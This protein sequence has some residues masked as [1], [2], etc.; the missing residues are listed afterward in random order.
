MDTLVVQRLSEVAKSVCAAH[1]FQY[2][3]SAGHGAF[4]AT[5]EAIN[6]SGSRIA[7]KIYQAGTHSERTTR[8]IDALVRLDHPNLPLFLTLD[9]ITHS[10][11]RYEFSTEEFLDGGTLTQRLARGLLD[12]SAILTLGCQLIQAVGHVASLQLVHRDIKPD[13]IMFRTDGISSVLVDFGLVRDLSL[14][15]L[16]QTWL[17]MGPGT[18]FFAAPEQLNNAKQLIDW[19]TDQFALGVVLSLCG[20]GQHPH[21][22]QGDD[23]ATIVKRVALR[24]QSSEAFRAWAQANSLPALV[25]MTAG[26]P[27]QRFRTPEALLEAWMA[28]Q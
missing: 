12:R 20:T 28:Q 5:F 24:E 27:V 3:R 2:V 26:W 18:P 1:N 15:S 21:A 4:K 13:N 16:T 23:A 25:R 9:H 11:Q 14:H 10:G 22:H 7:L 6:S 17:T 8:E 19:R